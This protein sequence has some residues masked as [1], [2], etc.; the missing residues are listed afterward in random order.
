MLF[1]ILAQWG[2]PAT[3]QPQ[4]GALSA[5]W[6]ALPNVNTPNRTTPRLF[7]FSHDLKNVG[8]VTTPKSPGTSSFLQPEMRTYFITRPDPQYPGLKAP[9]FS[10][11]GLLPIESLRPQ[12]FR[13]FFIRTNTRMFYFSRP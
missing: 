3:A 7:F 12:D 1:L 5:P 8:R 9:K 10:P 11:T 4:S 2:M 6:P 13:K